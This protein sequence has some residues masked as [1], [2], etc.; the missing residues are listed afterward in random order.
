MDKK[1]EYIVLYEELKEHIRSGEISPGNRLPS[2]REF[3]EHYNLSRTTVRSALALLERENYIVK[4]AG[5]GCTVLAP[6]S[7]LEKKKL[8]VGIDIARTS[9]QAY[10]ALIHEELMGISRQGSMELVVKTHNELITGNGID[11]AI[12]TILTEEELKQLEQDYKK[13]CPVV[14]LNRMPVNPQFAYFSVDYENTSAKIVSRL[15][16]NGAKKIAM[17]GGARNYDGGNYAPYTRAQGW[18]KACMEHQGRVPEELF[19]HQ[20]ELYLDSSRFC[21]MMTEERPDVLFVACSGTLAIMV[22]ILKQMNILPGRD[23]DIISFDHA[24]RIAESLN[25]PISYLWMPF[26]SMA[27][28]SVAYIES[29]M[30]GGTAPVPKEIM[31]VQLVANNC[32]YLF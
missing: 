20:D 3:M 26:R 27:Q 8:R 10:Q 23:V 4:Q 17:I 18:R 9:D 28:R 25:V 31:D 22:V 7:G 19:I 11:G 30:Q 13:G 32:K 15:F 24:E 5:V 21:R 6:G 1:S 12:F 14:F 29:R 2:E 16:R